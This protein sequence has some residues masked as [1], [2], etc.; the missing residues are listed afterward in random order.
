M[1][2]E[3]VALGTLV[4]VEMMLASDK[5]EGEGGEVGCGC[6]IEFAKKCAQSVKRCTMQEHQDEW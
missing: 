5:W 6:L 1:R 2:R 3:G 4:R